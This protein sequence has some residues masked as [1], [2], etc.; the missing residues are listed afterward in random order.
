VLPP[1][2][3]IPCAI[4]WPIL[5]SCI[6]ARMLSI[7]AEVPTDESCEAEAFR[8]IKVQLR[9]LELY[10]WVRLKSP[11][12]RAPALL[13]LFF[14]SL[15]PAQDIQFRRS[16]SG[17]TGNTSGGTFV[18]DEIRTRFIY[19][20]DKSFIVYFEWLA[21]AGLHTISAVWKPPEGQSSMS[22]DIK[23]NLASGL[24]SAYWTF[25]IHADD[26]PGVWTLETRV[27]GAP[28]GTHSFELFVPPT[29]K[30]ETLQPRRPTTD[31]LYRTAQGSLVTVSSLNAATGERI[32]TSLGFI[33]AQDRVATAFQS[34][35]GATAVSVTF[36]DG[37]ETRTDFLAGWSRSSDWALIAVP[38]GTRKAMK[39]SSSSAAKVGEKALA[40]TLENQKDTV[41]A[42]VEITGRTREPVRFNP[43]L[44]AVSAVS[45]VLDADG[46][47]MGIVG[48][49]DTP[50]YR[51]P[52]TVAAASPTVW[53]ANDT[54][55][56]MAPIEIVTAQKEVTD[57]RSLA[58]SGIL[59][60]AMAPFV[61][62]IYAT[63]TDS[64]NK[65]EG[66]PDRNINEF[67]RR[68]PNLWVV[69][70]WERRSKTKGA[71]IAMAIYDASNRKRA[72]V[73]P[74]KVSF[75]DTP[76]RVTQS[77][78][79]AGFEPGAYRVDILADGN[80]VW[81]RLVKVTV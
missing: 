45:P 10:R 57:L 8:E 73:P 69:S 62:L 71:Q 37:S 48:A 19:P 75:G 51:I 20:Q 70:L 63:T 27:D 78:S 17:P 35:D 50:G 65:H 38:T 66:L 59:T 72:E 74:K 28:G 42:V 58:K 15:A 49:W 55:G 31:E 41:A 67:S 80:V 22:P 1:V 13:C 29:P 14:T 61:A 24:L 33:Y 26:P 68:N 23:V 2:K 53:I 44:T 60:P 16:L 18:F 54:V 34:I 32:D 56:A 64:L 4:G 3:V 43:A 21:P 7:V 52:S 46:A 77:L 81:R 25:T 36:A 79:L 30:V 40:F 12:T 39:T 11:M 76:T 9:R 6:D 47:V 5:S